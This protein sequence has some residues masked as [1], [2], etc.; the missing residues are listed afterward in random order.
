VREPRRRGEQDEL[1]SDSRAGNS[2]RARPPPQDQW[3]RRLAVVPQ[4]VYARLPGPVRIARP[5][6]RLNQRAL[7]Y[8][9]QALT[10]FFEAPRPLR[11]VSGVERHRRKPT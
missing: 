8:E 3:R 2:G 10:R 1:H 4:V 9:I 11:A 6:G 7:E 5:S